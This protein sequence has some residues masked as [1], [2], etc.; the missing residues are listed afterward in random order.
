MK[1]ANKYII[2]NGI[3]QGNF[4]SVFKAVC[5]KT[6]KLYAAKLENVESSFGLIKHEAAILFYLNTQKCTHLPYIYYYGKQIPY[7]CLVMTYYEGSLEEI[8]NTLTLHEKM[9]WWNTMLKTIEGIHDAGIVHRDI[10]PAHFMELSQRMEPDRF[11]DGHFIF[12]RF[13]TYRRSTKR[14]YY[15]KPEL[16]ELSRSH[17]ERCSPTR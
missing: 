16:C 8:G 4:G 13:A 17:G 7:N 5:L 6:E 3:G 1:I 2:Q 11:W 14:T 10:K 12:E 15:W 9:K